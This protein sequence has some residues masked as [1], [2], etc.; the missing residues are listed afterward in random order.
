M[1]EAL[2]RFR[3]HL[4]DERRL[5][6]HTV[7][8]YVR[9]VA[10][11][12]AH[13]AE[14]LGRPPRPEDLDVR[15]IRAHLAAGHRRLAPSTQA[16]RLSVLR[17]FG[18]FLRREGR[19]PDNPALLVRRPKQPK[20]LPVALPPEDMKDLVEAA[21]PAA[22]DPV[23]VRD[24]AVLEVLYG[25]GLRVS[26][27]AG[28]DLDDVREE[29]GGSFLRVRG[30]KGGKDRQVPLGRQARAALDAWLVRRDELVQPHSP[31][32]ALFLGV[33]GGRLS[34]RTIRQMVY[35][36]C[37]Q[38]GTRARVGPHGLRHAFATHLLQSGCDLRTIQSML[39]HASLSTTQRYTHLDLGRIVDVYERAHP[40]A[41]APATDEG[42]PVG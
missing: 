29:H 4:A 7:R 37:G 12:L 13:T 23:D 8:A 39:G 9:D 1:E 34:V 21:D 18:E 5:S 10:G 36:R 2:E 6:P 19:V 16:R 38:A 24:R 30:G 22:A 25:A 14:R 3:V 17:G 35:R 42:G 11:F 20:H 40:R 41:Q 27:C 31:P 15:A 28:L 26:E 32:Q 33:R